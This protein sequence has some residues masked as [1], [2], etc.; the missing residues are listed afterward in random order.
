MNEKFVVYGTVVKT[1]ATLKGPCAKGCYLIQNVDLLLK[2]RIYPKV[3]ALNVLFLNFEVFISSANQIM[4]EKIY[5]QNTGPNTILTK[6]TNLFFTVYNSLFAVLITFVSK[7]TKLWKNSLKIDVNKLWSNFT[8][9]QSFS[10][11]QS[12]WQVFNF[13]PS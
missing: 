9:S 12:F 13:Y 2:G 8:T 3:L 6:I 7:D 1:F 10:K 11:Q 4:K 5:C